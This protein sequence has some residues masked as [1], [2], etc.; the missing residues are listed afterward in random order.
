MIIIS[1]DAV[2][3]K[4]FEI[5]KE[6][7]NFKKLLEKSSYSFEVESVYPSLTYPAHT[8]IITG[9]YPN[10]HGIINN[11]LVQPGNNNPDWF[12][13]R[14]KIQGET[15]CDL[16]KKKGMKIANLLWPVMAKGDIDYNLPEIFPNKWWQNQIIISLLN[17]SIGYQLELNNK[18][19]ELR[20]GTKQPE[21]DNFIMASLLHTLREKQPG[22]T[23]VH[24]T[25][26]DSQRHEY[27]YRSPEA[28]YALKR[29]DYRIGEV[30]N[31][32]HSLGIENDTTIV[33]LGDHSFKDA[34]YVIKLNKLFINKGWITIDRKGNIVDWATFMNYCDGS[35]YIYL[36]DNT[37]KNLLKVIRETL[38]NF[39]NEN[40][41][42]IEKIL[43]SEEAFKLGA[44]RSCA[45]MLEAKEGYYFINDIDGEI[46]EETGEKYHKA[47]HGY[48]PKK[49]DY[50]TFFIISGKGI[51]KDYNIGPMHL[52]DEGPTLA[53]IL[54]G[55]L[56]KADGKVLE[57]IRE[58][59]SR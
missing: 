19:K 42:C 41:N 12:W 38:E 3:K 36:K 1:L 51:K 24:L 23:L 59:P 30:L 6:L 43:T 37:N 13:H 5:L 14:S 48:S 58:K 9:K 33:I 16:A 45:L 32:L 15:L 50:E 11:I 53:A 21:L 26:V 17:G 56:P 40:N 47:T 2:D 39:S 34:D 22:L 57:Q 49:K 31:C 4:D 10:N 7:P 28:L 35:A 44:D 8:T 20:N 27:G 18:F 25:D 55:E 29:H 52:V 46:I 54:E